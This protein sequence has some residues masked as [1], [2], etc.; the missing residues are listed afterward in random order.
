[1]KLSDKSLM[2]H[3]FAF[4]TILIASFNTNFMK[5]LLNDWIH[6]NGL[7]LLRA[8]IATAGFWLISLLVPSKPGMPRPKRR[9]ILIIML[10]GALGMGINL[11]LYVQGLSMTGPIEA[12]VIRT[13]QPIVVIA[14][15][16]IFLNEAFSKDKAFGILL[17]MA[18]TIYISIAPH[19][20]IAQNSWSGNALIFLSAISMALFLILVKPYTSKFDTLTVMKWMSLAMLLVSIPFGWDDLREARLFYE[21]A[22]WH[23]YSELAFVV[24]MAGMVSYFLTVEALKYI[25]P[26]IES[27]YIY[28]LPILGATVAIVLGLQ[29]FS[30]HDPIAFALIVAGFILINRKKRTEH[31]ATLL[32]S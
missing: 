29:H 23:I 21:K 19:H 11:L 10:G 17:G 14:L 31:P 9:D 22:D 4:S 6:A 15:S 20:E 25:S 2:G 30:W 13:S 16:A 32:H 7:V 8:I 27:T 24:I 26:F 5:V 18:G 12:L 1:M 3:L 28:V